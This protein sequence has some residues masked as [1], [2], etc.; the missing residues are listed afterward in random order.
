MNCFV[1]KLVPAWVPGNYADMSMCLMPTG[2]DEF[3]EE[4]RQNMEYLVV[5]LEK[6]YEDEGIKSLG[7]KLAKYYDVEGYKINIIP[8]LKPEDALTTVGIT[9]PS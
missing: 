8:V 9:P 1:P 6:G 3:T 4:A 7:N 5:E 2:F